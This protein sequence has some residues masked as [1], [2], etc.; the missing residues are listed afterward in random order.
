MKLFSVIVPTYKAEKYIAKTIKSVLAQTYSHFELIVVDDES[1]DRSVEICRQF[2]DPR[3]KIISQKNRGLAGARNTGIRHAR[4]D[5]LAFLDAD[6]LWLPEKLEKHL[7]HLESSPQVGI[8]F[9]RSEFIDSED[10]S[11]G[12]YQ[13]PKLKNITAAHL[14]CRNPIGNGSSPVIRC[15]VFADIKFQDNLYGIVEDFYFDEL[16]RQSEDIEC[17]IRIAIATNWQIEGIPEALTLYR[18]NLEGLSADISKQLI[19]WEKVIEKTYSYAPELVSRW[20]KVARAYQLRYLA[21]RAVRSKD[22]NRAVNL[23]NRSL[24]TNWTA[25]LSEPR[26]TLLTLGA[27]Y[28]LKILPLSLYVHLEN[29]GLK[30]T[31]FTQ[32]IKI[33]RDRTNLSYTNTLVSYLE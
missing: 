19:S 12:T 6:D 15:E 33:K 3:L 17:W 31:G 9:S 1:P 10:R 27:A 2:Q 20:E 5:Y 14:L 22:G 25:L 32:K 13:M 16:F 11:I 30:I 8:S 29:I 26:R 28:L 7:Q 4:G 18:V 23:I 21:R 24:L